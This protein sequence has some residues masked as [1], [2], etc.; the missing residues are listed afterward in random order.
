MDEPVN[1]GRDRADHLFVTVSDGAD[2]DAG[3]EVQIAVPVHIPDVT[4]GRVVHDQRIG[5]RGRRS[6]VPLIPPQERPGAGPWRSRANMQGR[7][8]YNYSVLRAGAVR[9]ARAEKGSALHRR[10]EEHTSELQSRSDLVCRLLLEKK[11]AW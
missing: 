2:R 6:H 5:L 1:L 8:E 10:S 7:H 9:K 4:S 11:T 3:R